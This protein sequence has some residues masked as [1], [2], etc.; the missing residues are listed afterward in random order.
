V[1]SA[2]AHT[3]AAGGLAAPLLFDGLV[4]SRWGRPL[5]EE[6]RASGIDAVHATAAVWEGTE[7]TIKN[8]ERFAREFVDNADLIVQART[9]QDIRDAHAG[10]RTAVLLGFQNT[11]AL[12]GHLDRAEVFHALGVRV[13]QLTYNNQNFVGGSC[14]EPFDS[15]LS[16]FGRELI[17]EM[18]RL[19]ILVDLSHV[20]DRTS[21]DAIEL[22]DG[23]V[24]FTHANPR[25]FHDAPRNKPD[26]VIRA[27]VERGGVLGL[28]PYALLVP[29]SPSG[30]GFCD[31]STFCAMVARAVDEL[32][33]DHVALGTDSTFGQT[34]AFFQWLVAGN[35]TRE[36][37]IDEIPPVP[38]WAQGPA[39]FPRIVEALASEGLSD[40]EIRAVAGGN[41]LRLLDEVQHVAR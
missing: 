25:W 12:E 11:D 9:A 26:D 8:L 34:A 36:Q 28:C 14:Y 24:A 15:G 18:G 19:G 13:M 21:R 7:A 16:R 31:L 6:L 2:T 1:E 41:W 17:R 4:I 10:S 37:L 5:W 35:W 3:D 39:D 33:V 29:P 22:S 27:L 23:P 30:E 32:G 20:G 40:A 38:E